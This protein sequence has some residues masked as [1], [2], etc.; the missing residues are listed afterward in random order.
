MKGF[1]IFGEYIFEYLILTI[2]LV[3]SLILVIPFIPVYIG[4]VGYLTH[5]RDDRMLKDI[6][7]T[8]KEN[9]KIILKFTIFE[10]IIL[11][12]S[13][14]NIYYFRQNMTGF[15]TV[16]VVISY[17][18][19]FFGVVFLAHAPMIIIGMNVNL[20][21]LILNTFLFFFGG[22]INSIIAIAA[23]AGLTAIALYIPYLVIVLLYFAVVIVEYFTRK[24]FLF[25]KA[26]KLNMSVEELT[27]REQE[28][29]Y[30]EE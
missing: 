12:F 29:T 11:V 13:F 7:T 28:D 21:Q 18:F 6:F 26:R 19:L 10:L 30:L 22:V 2:I 27:K 20:R 17:V 23:L 14:L 24:N 25:L 5:K 16:I 1:R 8:I 15:N 4:V 9:W 3:L